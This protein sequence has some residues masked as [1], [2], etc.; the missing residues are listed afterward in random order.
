[1]KELV[2]LEAQENNIDKL[3]ALVYTVEDIKQ[4]LHIGTTQAYNLMRSSAFPSFQINSKHYITKEN[5]NKWLNQHTNKK[6]I[7]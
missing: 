5:L 1:M 4:L 6:F 2:E 3:E 7:I